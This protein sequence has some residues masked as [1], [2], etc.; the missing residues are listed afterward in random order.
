MKSVTAIAIF[1]CFIGLNFVEGCFNCPS[2]PAPAPAPAP[3][4]V[5]IFLLKKKERKRVK[6]KKT[7]LP[8]F[9]SRLLLQLLLHLWFVAC[10]PVKVI[11]RVTN[12]YAYELQYFNL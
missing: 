1:A 7:L 3:A 4:P 6:K 11:F 9:D 10:A 5:S 12:L 8:T 2:T